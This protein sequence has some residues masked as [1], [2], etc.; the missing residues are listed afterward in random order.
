MNQKGAARLACALCLA[1]V[2]AVRALE[3]EYA[4]ANKPAPTSVEGIEHPLKHAFGAPR[5]RSRLLAR[6]RDELAHLPPFL[7]DSQLI[8]APRLYNF[9]REQSTAADQ[10][11]FA[12]GG[13]FAYRS[14]SWRERARIA[15]TAYTTQR[16]H[17]PREAGGGG[18]LG[19]E[20]NSFGVVGEAY[21]EL[22]LAPLATMRVYR[23]RLNLPYF[24]AN[25]SRMI[26]VTHESY[27][28]AAPDPGPMQWVVGH[29]TR[30]KN[31]DSDRFL[32]LSVAAGFAGTN[33]GA[34]LAGMRWSPDA[35]LSLTAVNFAS[36]DFLDIAYAE[37]TKLLRLHPDVSI[38]SSL[39]ATYQGSIGEA[40][41]GAFSTYQLG[42]RAALSYRFAVLSFA[43]SYTDDDAPLRSPYGG[44]PSFLSLMLSDFDRAGE[45]AWLASLSY[46]LGR[47]GL[48]GVGFNLK[49]ARG[50][51]A[52]GA[53]DQDEFDLTLDIKPE[54]VA[55]HGL[56]FRFRFATLEAD[57]GLARQDVRFILNY[58][59][60]LH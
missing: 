37:G 16:L 8:F 29:V 40:L 59:I 4:M 38:A 50:E 6:L 23:Q 30:M 13:A 48:P 11:S 19:P 10:V 2:F 60:D 9:D 52:G 51:G 41:G 32:P 28:L 15:V 49:Y 22:D 7:R 3:P 14:G 55:V 12:A 25:D 47:F 21:A 34:T 18:L 39:Q 26:P 54:Q 56:W 57:D 53:P 20:Q 43:V 36:W 44:S 17:G 46:G 27:L 42:A 45:R 58:E 31:H 5:E 33:E 35:T 1:S 24:N